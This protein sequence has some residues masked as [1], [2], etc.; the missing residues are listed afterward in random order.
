MLQSY[1]ISAL[2]PRAIYFNDD[3]Y[4]AWIDHT[5]MIEVTTMDSAMG[6]VFYTML[7]LP[8]QT[9][10]FERETTRCLNCH[11]TFSESGG[12]VPNFLFLSAYTRQQHEIITNEV[13][14]HT[15]DA[16]PLTDRWGG[17]YVTGDLGD[18]RHLG[19][20]MPPASG[21]MPDSAV[22]ARNYATLDSLF[23][24]KPY[25]TDKSDVVALLVLQHQVDVHNLIIHADY[26]CRMLME[27]QR[28]GSSSE[29]IKWAQLSPLMQ[30]RFKT[31][32]DPL[33][34]GMLM[35][36]AAKL[37]AP[38]HGN[39]GFSK[40][41]EARGPHDAHGRSL[42]D[43]DLK[44]RLFKYPLSFLIYSEGFDYLPISAKEYV[45]DRLD[46]ILTGRDRSPTFANLSAADRANILEILRATKP[47]FVRTV[48]RDQAMRASAENT[49]ASPDEG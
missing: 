27:R 8:N 2:P 32:L 31:L 45:Y 49:P 7:E 21:E 22:H 20:I 43:L 5:P 47:E 13:A 28:K 25:L 9:P 29:P 33:V 16:T 39:S 40:S 37:P 1:N 14:M 36:D 24:T 46:E 19:N 34:E 44:T 26:K 30:K 10:R 18:I 6:E 35:V 12:G 48:A 42:R 41:F 23:D 15:S 38:I 3:T 17:W 4:V 11:D